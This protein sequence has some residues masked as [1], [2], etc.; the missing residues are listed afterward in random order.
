MNASEV[1]LGQ[2]YFAQLSER[3]TQVRIER[4][5]TGGGWI[6]RV[7]SHGKHAKIKSAAQLLRRCDDEEIAAVVR[8]FEPNRRSLVEPVTELPALHAGPH[9]DPDPSDGRLR[10]NVTSKATAPPGAIRD[11]TASFPPESMSLL[12]AAVYVLK[13]A[14]KPL[15]TREIVAAIIK[16]RLWNP[17][18]ATPWGTL[19]AAIS[20]DIV[21]NGEQSRFQKATRGLFNVRQ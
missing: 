13:T 20:R 11:E 16:L 3:S 5:A 6:A 2:C 10:N 18:G 21:N 9:W 8:G 19:Y 12:D 17:S 4:P 15:S 14:K 7:L 1:R